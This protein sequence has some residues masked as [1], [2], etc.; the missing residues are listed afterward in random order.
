M[1]GA[2]GVGEGV[3]AVAVPGTQESNRCRAGNCN[4]QVP[5]KAG[6]ED[7]RTHMDNNQVRLVA[8]CVARCVEDPSKLGD[9]MPVG[10]GNEGGGV[11]DD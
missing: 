9:I 3:R 2:E 1:E 11:I 5:S 10:F 8:R 4:R 6:T 7:V